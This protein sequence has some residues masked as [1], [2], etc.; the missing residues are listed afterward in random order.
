MA[1]LEANANLHTDS[2]QFCTGTNT[3]CNDKQFAN[4]V[5]TNWKA[6]LAKNLNLSSGSVCAQICNDNPL[7][8]TIP[9]YTT[10]CNISFCRQC[11]TNCGLYLKI[12]WF[13]H[14]EQQEA[15]LIKD[16]FVILRIP[17][18]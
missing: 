15:K 9:K 4:A 1:Y 6:G 13:S 3:N 8:L 18:R 7:E 12:A 2:Y 11:K 10:G 5:L 17:V 16:N 14:L